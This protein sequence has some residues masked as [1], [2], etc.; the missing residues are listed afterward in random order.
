MTKERT[1]NLIITEIKLVGVIVGVDDG[2]ALGMVTIGN[3]SEGLI[4]TS[5]GKDIITVVTVAVVMGK[6]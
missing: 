1:R 5:D 4:I 3:D 6:R 2:V